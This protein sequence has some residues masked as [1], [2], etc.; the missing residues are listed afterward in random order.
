M[1]T[2]NADSLLRESAFA[3]AGMNRCRLSLS[4]IADHGRNGFG[5]CLSAISG[6]QEPQRLGKSG[7]LLSGLIRE[8]R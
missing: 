2:P 7:R 5:V 3:F 6:R 8:P 4:E 1:S